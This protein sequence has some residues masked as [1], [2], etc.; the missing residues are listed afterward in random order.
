MDLE[1]TSIYQYVA[2]TSARLEPP[3]SSKPILTSGYEMRPCLINMIRDQSF[4]DEDD[5]NPYFHPNCNTPG[6]WLPHLHL[7]FMNMSIMHPFMKQASLFT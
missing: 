7:H 4:S 5:E 3:E 6:V 1:S 2:P